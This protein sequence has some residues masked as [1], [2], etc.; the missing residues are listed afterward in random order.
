VWCVIVA[1]ILGL[2]RTNIESKDESYGIKE[3][4]PHLLNPAVAWQ[5][6]VTIY[7]QHDLTYES[8]R[9]PALSGIAGQN[10]IQDQYLAGIWASEMPHGLFWTS[11]LFSEVA[12]RPADYRAPSWAWSSMLGP[13]YFWPQRGLDR[14]TTVA[15]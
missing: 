12:R 8:D 13:I 9:L 3:M 15:E 6:I 5:K 4:F 2:P 10:R 7:S 14:A 1:T 11:E